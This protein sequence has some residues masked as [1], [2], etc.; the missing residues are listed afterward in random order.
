MLKNWLHDIA[1]SVQAKSGVTPL[2]FVW[3]AIV[4]LALLTEHGI[5]SMPSVTNEPLE[6]EAAR[7]PSR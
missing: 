4:A 3:F 2:L 5:T 1:L 7:S 6:I